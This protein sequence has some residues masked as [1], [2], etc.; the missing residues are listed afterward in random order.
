MRVNLVL[1]ARRLPFATVSQRSAAEGVLQSQ[2][3]PEWTEHLTVWEKSLLP[4]VVPFVREGLQ[5][6]RRQQEKKSRRKQR[7]TKDPIVNAREMI[8]GND[9]DGE[10]QPIPSSE[11]NSRDDTSGTSRPGPSSGDD[12]NARGEE[13]VR[14]LK[15]EERTGTQASR[16]GDLHIENKETEEAKKNTTVEAATPLPISMEEQEEHRVVCAILRNLGDLEEAYYRLQDAQTQARFVRKKLVGKLGAA[17]PAQTHVATPRENTQE[18]EHVGNERDALVTRESSSSFSPSL[19]EDEERGEEYSWWPTDEEMGFTSPDSQKENWEPRRTHKSRTHPVSHS[20]VA[21]SNQ[22]IGEEEEGD[23]E[24]EPS[25]KSEPEAIEEEKPLSHETAK[26]RGYGASTSLQYMKDM[27]EA[28]T[29]VPC[30]EEAFF[31]QL[32]QQQLTSWLRSEET[33]KEREGPGGAADTSHKQAHDVEGETTRTAGAG[34]EKGGQAASVGE[35][36]LPQA[37]ELAH[38]KRRTVKHL[39]PHQEATGDAEMAITAGT[40][41]TLCPIAEGMNAGVDIAMCFDLALGGE[42]SGISTSS[43][44]GG[45]GLHT[46]SL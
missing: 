19:S 37:K 33:E 43:V 3:R 27:L 44:L 32:A 23:A 20:A 24:G 17:S 11:N 12:D 18:G 14:D 46:H 5:A 36:S 29:G 39:F 15:H 25:S 42:C 9:N 30:D 10:D 7:T 21:C 45:H 41:G 8:E 2:W 4:C 34:E 26:N 1:E 6:L 31:L 22:E 16:E 13:V 35:V 28:R 40:E 38:R